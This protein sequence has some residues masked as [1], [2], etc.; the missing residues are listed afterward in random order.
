MHRFFVPRDALSENAVRLPEDVSRQIARVLR[1]RPRDT[2]ALFD[3]SGYEW[4]A[5]ID[6]V[7]HRKVVAT[8]TQRRSPATEPTVRVT[9]TQALLKSDRF[10]LVLQKAVELGVHAV[11]PLVCNRTVPAQPSQSRT[12][13]WERI[14]REAAE[15]SGRVRVPAILGPTPL[16]SAADPNLG[17]AIVLWEGERSRSLRSVLR[18]LCG[19]EAC[20]IN[21]IVGP[22]GGFEAWEV[23]A[24]AAKS[25]AAAGMGPRTLRAE[26][27][28]IAALAAVMYE[29]GELGPQRATGQSW[30]PAQGPGA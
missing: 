13:R 22:E 20:R 18:S 8:V 15:Q 17:A 26:T 28:S 2:I 24:L 12:A 6:K 5:R 27:A 21:L 14:V 4:L 11:Q 23:E 16:Q 9:L 19:D 10:E 29:L 1:L 25:V 3:G 30:S 7:T